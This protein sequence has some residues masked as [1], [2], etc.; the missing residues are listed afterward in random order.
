KDRAF[1][2]RLANAL[3]QTRDFGKQAPYAC[4]IPGV[5]FKVW[6]GQ[7]HVEVALCFHCSGAEVILKD[8][9]SNPV[10]SKHS[11]LGHARADLL[12]LCQEAL[13]DDRR[14]QAIKE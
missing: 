8:A 10:K 6:K 7:E 1:A 13:P 4:F 11:E 3:E 5:G 9:H 12:K 2:I 14:L